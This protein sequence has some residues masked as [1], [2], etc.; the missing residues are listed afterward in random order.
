[1]SARS[2]RRRSS[3]P[4]APPAGR[5]GSRSARWRAFIRTEPHRW[6]KRAQRSSASPICS[7]RFATPASRRSRRRRPTPLRMFQL[8]VRGD[9]AWVDDH[10]ARAIAN[11]YAAFC[12]TVDTA[13]LQ[14][15]RARHR[16][17]PH[18]RRPP[19]RL[20]PRIPGGARLA[21]GRAHQGCF[22]FRSR[23]RASPPPR[24]PRSRS[25]M[26][27]I[28]YV[29]NH[30][31]RQLDHGRGSM[32][33]LPEIVD[34]VAGR[35]MIIDRRRLLSR[36]RHRQGDRGRAPIWSASAACSAMRSRRR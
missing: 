33:V 6:C 1:M 25:I 32:D 11:G 29:S 17:A 18:D 8:Y 2:M 28:I 26:A 9:E 30:G 14:P 10:V 19:T 31:G 35:A 16:Q 20:G 21:H 12:L 24:T 4:E 23:S 22:T 5:A 27:S 15:A 13:D 3:R 36:H 34:A 7:A